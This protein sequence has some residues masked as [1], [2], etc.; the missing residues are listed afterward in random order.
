MDSDRVIVIGAGVGGLVTAVL[1][2]SQ[3]IPVTVIEKQSQSG[4]KIRRLNGVDS[5][6]TVLTMPW[7]LESIFSRAGANLSDY[8]KLEPLSVLARHTWQPGAYASNVSTA[9]NGTTLD[10][11][12]DRRASA[13]AIGEFSG[14]AQAKQFLKFCDDAKRLYQT[15]EGPYIRSER[16]S[17]ARM[18]SDL[19]LGGLATLA[20]LGPFGLPMPSLWQSLGRYFTDP[21]L[22]Q[23]FG[24]Y[25]TYCGS[26]PWLAPATL[27]LIAQVEMDGV[28]T[29]KDGM[30]GVVFAL[31]KLAKEKGVQF[32]FDCAVTEIL[33]S[34][35]RANG[36]ITEFGERMLAASLVFNGDVSALAMGHLGKV[37]ASAVKPMALTTRRA[38]RSLSAVTWSIRTPRLVSSYRPVR[39]NVFF[40]DNY[41][42]E[43]TDIFKRQKLPNA[44]TVYLCAQDRNDQGHTEN[45][46][47][48]L[49][50]LVNAPAQ[51]DS[52]PLKN[53]P[54]SS[55]E[56]EQCTRQHFQLMAN[57]GLVIDLNQS[58]VQMTTPRQFNQLFPVTGGA[59][60]GQASH[61]WMNQF[62]RMGATS[63]IPGLY[64]AGGSVHPGPGVPMAAMSGLLAAETLMAHRDLTSKL[65][66]VVIAGGTSMRSATAGNLV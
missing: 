51:G 44:G 8:L 55:Q 47:D 15:L 6:P 7:I 17:F 25:A 37:A 58:Q 31:E 38:K 34:A 18:T 27:M 11:Y 46:Y 45:S 61:G 35:G 28:F 41:A 32:V 59:L 43:F 21:R 16:P 63:L 14:A 3:G 10:L 62:A 12:A 29:N 54:F 49:L 39:H 57:C 4:G 20:K 24:R 5:G 30:Q 23:L 53:D 26:T 65:S 13:Q 66:R 9:K 1:L 64:L 33:V 52:N 22:R 60:Y 19:G 42:Q 36:V 40:T 50:C 48:H 56:L 2:A